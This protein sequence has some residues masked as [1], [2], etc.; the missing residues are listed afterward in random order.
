M[1]KEYANEFV[2]SEIMPNK[3]RVW[4]DMLVPKGQLAH[5][6]SKV[7]LLCEVICT[8]DPEGAIKAL[9][10]VA[11]ELGIKLPELQRKGRNTR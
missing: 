3:W 7:H 5:P 4:W 8:D 10:E 1:I 11:R 6:H 2:A 9:A